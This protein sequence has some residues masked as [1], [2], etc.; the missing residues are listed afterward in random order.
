[1]VS[2]VL[3]IM[4]SIP[5][6]NKQWLLGIDVFHN[7]ET[8]FQQIFSKQEAMVLIPKKILL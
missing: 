6:D 4:N 2:K 7:H 5:L 3:W 1:M 8:I